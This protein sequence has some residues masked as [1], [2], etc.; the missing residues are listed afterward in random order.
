MNICENLK[1]N[2]SSFEGFELPQTAED[3]LIFFRTEVSDVNNIPEHIRRVINDFSR[4][5]I[6]LT[7]DEIIRETKKKWF[8]VNV[9]HQL[10]RNEKIKELKLDCLYNIFELC[11][12]NC[13]IYILMGGDFIEVC[14]RK[15]KEVLIE[16]KDHKSLQSALRL[17]ELHQ[18]FSL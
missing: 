8:T 14:K 12:N 13:D 18:R 3:A 2:P 5:I 6:P 15:I 7:E 4:N 11:I 1:I 17:I 10:E 9:K 16:G